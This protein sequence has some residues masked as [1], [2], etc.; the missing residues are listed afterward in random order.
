[1]SLLALG[2]L[3]SSPSN[4][5]VVAGE[6]RSPITV[7]GPRRISTGFLYRHRLTVKVC[8]NVASAA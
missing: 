1:V 3:L 8:H 7:A 2:S 4:L 6:G 5:S